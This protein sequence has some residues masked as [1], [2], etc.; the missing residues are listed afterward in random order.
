MFCNYPLP[1]SPHLLSKK[2]LGNTVQKALILLLFFL[3]SS[4]E[5]PQLL[6]QTAGQ[7]EPVEYPDR[8]VFTTQASSAR[9]KARQ[10][11]SQAI[12]K[13]AAVSGHFTLDR[14]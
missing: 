10:V 13:H 6:F 7:I 11:F 9:P 14:E 4:G 5:D 8:L 12:N 1:P 2:V 3:F